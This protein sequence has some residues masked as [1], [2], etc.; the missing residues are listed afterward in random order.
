MPSYYFQN[1][2]TCRRLVRFTFNKH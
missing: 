1:F 2:I